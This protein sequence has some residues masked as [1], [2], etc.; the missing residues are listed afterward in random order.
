M[1]SRPVKKLIIVGGGHASLPL[2]K[3]GKKWKTLG[4]EIVLV[5]ENPYLIYSGALPQFMGGFY[6]WEQTAIDLEKLCQTYGVSFI[7]S[8]VVSICGESSHIKLS[9]GTQHSYDYL[10]I[11]VGAKTVQFEQITNA[12]SVK[13]MNDLLSLRQRLRDGEIKKMLLAGGG[14]AGSELALNL[15]HP[16]SFANPEITIIDK[17]GRLLS[18]YPERL[19]DTVTDILN[20][21]KVRVNTNLK[22][23][24][25]MAGH[26]DATIIAV[27][28]QPG[29]KSISHDFKTGRGGRILTDQ[30]LKV[31]GQ[32]AVFAAG[33]TAD[34][35]GKNYR[36]IGVHAVKQGV[37]LRKNIKALHKG[38]ALTDYSPYLF[39]PLILSD[40]PDRAFYILNRFVSKGRWAAILKYV[41]DMRWLEKYTKPKLKRRSYIKL[42]QDGIERSY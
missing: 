13:P 19:S 16:D 40:G 36:Q 7:E 28:N 34:V 23:E 41:L 33:D 32:Q 9:N 39:N 25:E 10:V 31:S 20:E 29:S 11:N 22:F 37:V 35:D 21:R 26:Y 14:A 3:M 15:S 12:A 17:N 1:T 24:P 6:S 5:S 18:G 27:G 4:I 8:R 30:S 2:I 42:L 38:E